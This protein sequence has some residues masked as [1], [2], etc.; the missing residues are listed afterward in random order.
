MP[1]ADIFNRDG[2]KL[3]IQSTIITEKVIAITSNAEPHDVS[4][5]GQAYNGTDFYPC[6]SYSHPVHKTDTYER[7]NCEVF[8]CRGSLPLPAG[9]CSC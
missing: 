3:V 6:L 4:P 2:K 9:L 7:L 1:F 8:D 5:V